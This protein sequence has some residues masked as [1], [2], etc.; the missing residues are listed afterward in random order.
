ML[1]RPLLSSSAPVSN[2][3]SLTAERFASH[4]APFSANVSSV[5]ENARV[6]ICVEGLLRL[7]WTEGVLANA[8]VEVR[9]AVKQAVEEGIR[10]R[11]EKASGDGRRKSAGK[12]EEGWRVLVAGGER[13]RGVLGMV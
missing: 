11:E 7:L 9:K 3:N 10:V 5:G 12:G 13:M 1:L 4:F 6:G 2:A 8:G